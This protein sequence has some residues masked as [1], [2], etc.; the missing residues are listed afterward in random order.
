MDPAVI[1]EVIKAMQEAE[2][3]SP[4]RRVERRRPTHQGSPCYPR[5]SRRPSHPRPRR[6]RKADLIPGFRW[7]PISDPDPVVRVTRTPTGREPSRSAA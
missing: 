6:R 3:A 1:R 2:A 7:T 4:S 5:E